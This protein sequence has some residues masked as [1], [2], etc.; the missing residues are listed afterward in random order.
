MVV[1]AE[2]ENQNWFEVKYEEFFDNRSNFW[3][4]GDDNW[5]EF[6]DSKRINEY[7]IYYDGKIEKIIYDENNS[8]NKYKYI[9]HDSSNKKHEICEAKSNVTKEKKNGVVYKTKPTHSK[10]EFNKKVSEGSTERRIKYVNGDV[11]EYGKHPTKGK[12]WRLYKA[13]SKDVEL[14]RMPDSLSYK[15]DGVSIEYKFS[16]TKEDTLGQV[17]WL[18]L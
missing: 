11:A 15:K 4:Y 8:Q 3:Y 9:Y 6:R 13:T 14:V 2:P 17:V 18:V 7:H 16:S 1:D 5:F 12:I 10:I